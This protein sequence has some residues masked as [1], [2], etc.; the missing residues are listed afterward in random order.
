MFLVYSY[1]RISRHK[2]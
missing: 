2:S 1:G